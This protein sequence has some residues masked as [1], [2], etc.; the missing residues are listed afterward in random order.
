MSGVRDATMTC[1]CLCAAIEHQAPSKPGLD[2]WGVNYYSRGA[3]GLFSQGVPARGELM[4]DFGC[5]PGARNVPD[6]GPP[7]GSD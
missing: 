3:M 4:T 2:W 6:L 5:A 7:L 1:G